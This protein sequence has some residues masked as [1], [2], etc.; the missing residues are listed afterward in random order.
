MAALVLKFFTLG[1]KTAAKPLAKRFEAYVM[2]HDKFRQVVLRVAQRLHR[3][4]VN[5][6][7][8]LTEAAAKGEGR[9]V[10]VGELAD[11]NAI[12]LASTIVSEGFIFTV[13]ASIV[14]FEYERVRRKEVEKKVKEESFHKLVDD[15]HE[16]ERQVW[17]ILPDL[18]QQSQRQTELI[19]AMAKRIDDLEVHLRGLEE[20]K[21]RQQAKLFGLF[22]LG[23]GGAHK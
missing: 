3:W 17:R 21:A 9:R 20:D 2:G 22:S 19:E 7:V 8:E 23:G 18:Q 13:G 6:S 11:G 1:L 16:R 5:R 10:F 4:E 15:M 12:Q 14:I